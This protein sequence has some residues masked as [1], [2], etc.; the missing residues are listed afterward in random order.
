MTSYL[1]PDYLN[2]LKCDVSVVNCDWYIYYAIAIVIM[3]TVLFIIYLSKYSKTTLIL[4]TL[5]HLVLFIMCSIV[6]LNVCSSN[7]SKTLGITVTGISI[8]LT[9][10]LIIFFSK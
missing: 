3:F 7:A 8:L 4:S 10:L 9:L 2:P 1:T 6:I 5:C